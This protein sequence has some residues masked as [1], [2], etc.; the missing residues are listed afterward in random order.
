MSG[1]EDTFLEGRP[2]FHFV[3]SQGIEGVADRAAEVVGDVGVGESGG[4]R[5]GQSLVLVGSEL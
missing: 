3:G 2:V 4:V 1:L 5:A